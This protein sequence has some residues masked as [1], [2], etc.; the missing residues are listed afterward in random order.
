MGL[1]E[2]EDVVHGGSNAPPSLR[3]VSL[4]KR[5]ADVHH[6]RQVAH[7]KLVSLAIEQIQAERHRERATHRAFLPQAAVSLLLARD[8]P[9]M[10]APLVDNERHRRA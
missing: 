10:N 6:L 7:V 9:V 2:F 8:E 5:R 4:K 1:E 3:A